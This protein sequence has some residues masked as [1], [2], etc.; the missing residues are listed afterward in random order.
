MA[1][2]DAPRRRPPYSNTSVNVHRHRGASGA[3]SACLVQCLKRAARRPRTT[4][5]VHSEPARRGPG[6]AMSVLCVPPGCY[7]R[8]LGRTP[9]HSSPSS[10]GRRHHGAA[11]RRNHEASGVRRNPRRRR[12]VRRCSTASLKALTSDGESHPTVG[13]TNDS[14]RRLAT[15]LGH[16]TRVYAIACIRS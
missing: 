5:S 13:T 11:R 12:R 9:P 8:P 3:E 7:A 16:N 10:V 6:E 2:P 1:T 14:G 4:R 15:G